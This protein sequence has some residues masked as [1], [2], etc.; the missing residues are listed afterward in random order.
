MAAI[1]FFDANTVQPGSVFEAVPSGEYRVMIVDSAMEQT[2]NG[3]GQFLKLTLQI[4][5]G[6]HQGLTLFD[7]LN[8]VNSNP[9]AVEIAQRTLSAICHAIGVLQV[10][11]SAQLHHKPMLAKVEYKP[12]TEQYGAGND[13]KGYKPVAAQQTVQQAAAPAGTPPWQAA[14]AAA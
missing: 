5:E 12:P 14:A 8:L 1:G 4:L 10:T 6:P 13:I 11:D 3:T 2:K 7:R 9:K